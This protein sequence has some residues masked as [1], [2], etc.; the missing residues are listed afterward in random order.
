MSEAPNFSKPL[1][2]FSCAPGQ[3]CVLECRVQGNPTKVVWKR[4]GAEIED[5]FEFRTLHKGEICTLVIGELFPEDAGTFSCVASNENGEAET[6]CSL[7]VQGDFS[8][9]NSISTNASA[10][11]PPKPPPKKE[12]NDFKAE[13][14]QLIKDVAKTV[15]TPKNLHPQA[16]DKTPRDYVLYCPSAPAESEP[17]EYKVSSFEQRLINEIEYRLE[18]SPPVVEDPEDDVFE[19]VVIGSE[20]LPAF[21]IPLKNFSVTVGTSASLVCQ[22]MATPKPKVFWF[23]DGKQISKR[24]RHYLTSCNE[25]GVCE[26]KIAEL[27][28]E[29]DGNYT[30]LATNPLGRVSSTAK[31]AVSTHRIM[32][33]DMVA[34]GIIKAPK[35]PEK[36]AL[37]D[38]EEC[39]VEKYY[40]PVFVQKPPENIQA[41]EGKLVRFNV[42][43]TGLPL[44]DIAFMINGMP[45]RSDATHRIVVRENNVHS[46]LFEQVNI[47]DEGTYTIVAKN[48]AGTNMTRVNLRIKAREYA[49]P[50]TFV[51]R[52]SAT[53]A[54]EGDA[55]RLE[56]RVLAT[57]RPTITWKK[58]SDQVVHSHRTQLYQDDTGYACLQISQAELNDTAWYTCSAVNSAGIAS[59]NCKLD[60][61]CPRPEVNSR[62]MRRIRT[63][64]RYAN[65]A[66]IAG[67]DMKE[68]LNSDARFDHIPESEDL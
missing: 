15:T 35:T 10:Y 67:V 64:N 20:K 29:D 2:D 49:T 39:A 14:D 27:Y 44:P 47:M 66:K 42:K 8:N 7:S 32:N 45:V 23:K 58:G 16:F 21:V 26:L 19:E 31:I 57:P 55:V 40:R 22:V 18:Q 54:A 1:K 60:I 52:P 56:A 38:D 43:V 53:C 24:S 36:G 41:E 9:I 30:A 28:A 62:Q 17:Q 46:L 34:D 3:C 13:K 33:P 5:S 50:P 51:Q 11:T 4:E 61:Y 68:S 37:A 63:P 48:R 25:E 59:C 65:L 6:S 12:E